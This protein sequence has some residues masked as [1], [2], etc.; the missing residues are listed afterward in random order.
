MRTESRCCWQNYL[1]AYF[2][3]SLLDTSLT[4]AISDNLSGF[5]IDQVNPRTDRAGRGSESIFP[6]LCKNS[7]EHA[8]GFAFSEYRAMTTAD[9]IAIG[10]LIVLVVWAAA[11]QFPVRSSG[12]RVT[13]TVR[14]GG[15]REDA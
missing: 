4:P 3:Y 7:L 5:R 6:A 2:A 9:Y 15:K 12:S 8:C 11:T 10:V 14:G 1:V 13:S